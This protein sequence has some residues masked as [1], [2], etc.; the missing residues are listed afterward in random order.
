MWRTSICRSQSDTKEKPLFCVS[1][2]AVRI[3]F[4]ETLKRGS[5]DTL[6]PHSVVLV[7]TSHI[8]SDD[9]FAALHALRISPANES[10]IS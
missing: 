5:D 6:S 1:D 10:I 4:E 3:A 9:R 2:E 8:S 7:E